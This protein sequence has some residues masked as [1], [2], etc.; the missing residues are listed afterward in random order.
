M[1]RTKLNR[2]NEYVEQN[3]MNWNTIYIKK[4]IIKMNRM[5][6]II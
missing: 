3:W 6:I 4:G 2:T 1:C 5:N